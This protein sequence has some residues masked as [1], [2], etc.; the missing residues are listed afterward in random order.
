MKVERFSILLKKNQK[1]ATEFAK[2]VSRYVHQDADG[3]LPRK[4]KR[5]R[6]NGL[7]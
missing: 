7:N 6:D 5:E 2:F 1:L 3:L 4:N